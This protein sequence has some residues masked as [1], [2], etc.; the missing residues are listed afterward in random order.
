MYRIDLRITDAE[1]VRWASARDHS[2][3]VIECE[4]HALAAWL[5]V[6]LSGPGRRGYVTDMT[7]P[8]LALPAPHAARAQHQTIAP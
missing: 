1:G 4:S 8:R 5:A 7:W 6:Q 2:G 3:R